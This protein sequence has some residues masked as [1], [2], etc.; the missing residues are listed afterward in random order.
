MTCFYILLIIYMGHITDGQACWINA[1]NISRN[2][3]VV[4]NISKEYT[5]CPYAKL[6]SCYTVLTPKLVCKCR[7]RLTLFPLLEDKF[8]F[9][10]SFFVYLCYVHCKR[11]SSC[12]CRRTKGNGFLKVSVQL[13]FVD[14]NWISVVWSLDSPLHTC[15][16]FE[17]SA[18]FY[19]F[20]FAFSP[21]EVV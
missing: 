15:L 8:A 16:Y 1:K 6:H 17:V 11:L 5:D 2:N 9:L 14:F 4:F 3:S 20:M 10:F 21:M 12:L 7:R 18:L 13:S 19:H